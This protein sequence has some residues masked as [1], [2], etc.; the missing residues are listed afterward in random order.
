MENRQLIN[1]AQSSETSSTA[2]PSCSAFTLPS[3]GSLILD[4]SRT[5]TLTSDATYLPECIG[6][7][8]VIITG[9]GAAN[10][11]HFRDPFYASTLPECYALAASTVIAYML[12]IMLL[13]TPRTFLQEGVLVLERRGFTSGP[14][15]GEVGI[16]GRPNLQKVAALTVAISLTIATADT[17]RVA[18]AQYDFGYMDAQALENEVKNSLKLKIFRIISDT[19]LWLAQ[20]QTLIRLFPRQKEKIT[21]KWTA[22]AL[23]ILDELFSILNNFFYQGLS[24][25]RS[26][27]DAVPALSY[28]FR[29]VLSLLYAAW[30][31]YYSITKKEFAFYSPLMQNII[32]VALLS[33]VSVL[34]PVVFFITDIS[35]PDLAGWG[36]YVRWV[37]AAAASVV[38]WEWVERIEALERHEKKDCVLGREVFDGDE[39]LDV[40]ISSPDSSRWVT[41]PNK[42]GSMSNRRDDENGGTSSGTIE[43]KWPK[44]SVL[45]NRLRPRRKLDIES[46][47]AASQRSQVSFGSARPMMSPSKLS[48]IRETEKTSFENMAY[49]EP[50]VS[51]Q[52]AIVSSCEEISEDEIKILPKHKVAKQKK[53]LGTTRLSNPNSSQ[54]STKERQAKREM[55]TRLENF[56]NTQADKT[57]QV[58]PRNSAGTNVLPKTVIP[59]PPRRSDIGSSFHQHQENERNKPSPHNDSSMSPRSL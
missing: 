7:S 8:D 33:I 59:A 11:M 24:R 6:S 52:S 15:A 51:Q 35:K 37:G 27:I 1:V 42:I 44:V 54:T 18:E 31:I 39:M 17:F 16:G 21:I 57:R 53:E 32:L 41:P 49:A 5:L 13:I 43:S 45:A 50:K 3:N 22:L 2:T 9:S 12:V 14:S 19:I 36:D 28:L 26:F 47:K 23:I 4:A 30:V 38:V 34:V 56:T 25:P 58:R 48:D 40:G 20:A 10:H 46:G 29:L 55:R